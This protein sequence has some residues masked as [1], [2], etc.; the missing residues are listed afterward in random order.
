[1]NRLLILLACASAMGAPPKES[2]RELR[3]CIEGDPKTF[4]PLLVTESNSE[5]I[6][7]LT[8]GVLLRVNRATDQVQPELAETW[9]ITQ[10]GRAIVLRLR[11]HLKFSDG[12]PLTA[13]DVARTFH[14]ALDPE[15]HSPAGDILR[16]AAGGPEIVVGSPTEITIRY[17]RA[18]AG[19]ER[20][21]DS[22]AITPS[23]TGR[24]PASAGP[25]FVSEYAAGRFLRLVRNPNYWKRDSAGR[26]LPYIASIRIDIQQNHDIEL[27]RFL[28]GELD[29]VAPLEPGS[30]ERV[31]KEK[32]GAART[33]GPSLDSEFL[34]FN[35]APAKT[36]PEWKRKWFRSA[37]FRHAIS[38]AIHRDDLARIAFRGHAHPA[39]GPVSTANRFWF[40]AELQPLRTDIAAALRSLATEGFAL[41]NGVLRGPDGHAVEFSL[42][43]NSGSQTRASAAALI[44][45][46]LKQ[47]GVG[48]NIVSLDFGSLMERMTKS[49]DYDAVLLGFKNVDPDPGDEM[50]VWLSSGP[51]HA[52]WPSEKAP[53]TPWEAQIDQ[54][55][56]RQ[57]S[58]ATRDGRKKAIDRLQRVIADQEPIIY[59]VNPDFLYA[60]SPAVKGLQPSISPPQILW[61]VEWLRLE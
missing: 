56:L 39:A 48:V 18:R 27:T 40:N 45:S 57:A 44:Q 11:A 10:Q 53:A 5:T 9:K 12:S 6:R 32:P 1:M 22:L 13:D 29:L 4:D 20:L 36:L 23:G 38:G 3:F 35:Q 50:N 31:M 51:H 37:V 7:Y 17:K 21:F 19:L 42:A 26:Q 24:F 52:W 28:R 43:T 46:D 61:N 55:E 60:I 58:E 30:F 49:L 41:R 33:L 54:L 25:Y 47:I 34:W 2:R 8:A 59:L 14:R 16:T 15:V